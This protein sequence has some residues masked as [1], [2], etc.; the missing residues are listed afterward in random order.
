M[1]ERSVG[2]G[3]RKGFVPRGGKIIYPIIHTK[4]DFN[5][6]LSSE[7]YLCMSAQ[8]A[9]LDHITPPVRSVSVDIDAS[10]KLISIRF[11]F[12]RQPSD[13]ELDAASCAATE[14]ISDYEGGWDFD[15]QYPVIPPP[16]RTENL[17]LLV[18]HRCEDDWVSPDK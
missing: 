8:R 13:S 7:T 3:L 10:Q 18:F 6:D 15:E 2:G 11:V 1:R 17:R 12:E 9:L 14:I 5:M 16:A 4:G